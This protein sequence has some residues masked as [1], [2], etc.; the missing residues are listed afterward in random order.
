[1][2]ANTAN[3]DYQ[4]RGPAR[5]KVTSNAE[6]SP[7]FEITPFD[8]LLDVEMEEAGWAYGI[9]YN[10]TTI[11]QTNDILLVSRDSFTFT[12]YS[13]DTSFN[14][15]RKEDGSTETG[16]GEA[17]NVLEIKKSGAAGGTSY[18]AYLYTTYAHSFSDGFFVFYGETLRGA[19]EFVETESGLFMGNREMYMAVGI[20]TSEMNA[21]WWN[22]RAWQNTF[23]RFAMSLG[24]AKP[25]YFT[26]YWIS[27]Q[28]AEFTNIITTGKMVGRLFVHFY[29]SYAGA[30]GDRSFPETDGQK[31]FNLKDFRIVFYKNSMTVRNRYPN[32]YWN[33]IKEKESKSSASYVAKNGSRNSDEYS[34]NNIFA[35]DNKMK[36][37]YGVLLKPDW[38]TLEGVSYD[39]SS[40]ERPEQ[41]KANRIAGYWAAS[42]RKI[43]ASLL[44]TGHNG[45][46]WSI[47]PGYLLSMDGTEL[48][49]VSISRDWWDDVVKL[50]MMEI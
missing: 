13:G 21:Q 49:P 31:S 5:V 20:G 47:S 1:M 25:E 16:M 18:L 43:E 46:V 4:M 37:S 50:V 34:S 38:S 30:H 28:Q 14:K 41:H 42:K 12:A 45:E 35:T 9:P 23:T 17:H 48:Y 22:G 6:Y 15:V 39:G 8:D 2:F 10:N 11:A 19:D 40:D 44:A 24:N 7:A 26:R 3:T 32:S 29:G 27:Q 33:D 36:S